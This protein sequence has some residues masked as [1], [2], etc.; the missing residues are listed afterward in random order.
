MCLIINAF[1]TLNAFRKLLRL[2]MIMVFLCWW[3]TIQCPMCCHNCWN[4]ERVLA[5][6]RAEYFWIAFTPL[7][8]NY[9]KVWQGYLQ[10]IQTI[11]FVSEKSNLVLFQVLRLGSSLQG[12]GDG[13]VAAYIY[14][15]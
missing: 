3:I 1:V 5:P 2:F 7:V 11:P 12:H 9:I 13:I 14:S 10:M 4:L 6:Y 15:S 8:D